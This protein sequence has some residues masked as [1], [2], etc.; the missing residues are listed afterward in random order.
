MFTKLGFLTVKNLIRILTVKK[1][2]CKQKHKLTQTFLFNPQKLTVNFL[3]RKTTQNYV[4]TIGKHA[5]GM[6]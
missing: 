6:A 4:F 1:R 2:F 3:T 5:F